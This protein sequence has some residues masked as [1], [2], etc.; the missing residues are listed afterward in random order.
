MEVLHEGKPRGDVEITPERRKLTQLSDP[1][2]QLQAFRWEV[3]RPGVML[4]LT[5]PNQVQLHELNDVTSSW[6]SKLKDQIRL[7]NDVTSSLESKLKDQQPKDPNAALSKRLDD[8]DAEIKK[9]RKALEELG[10]ASK[11]TAELNQAI[12]LLKKLSA[13]KK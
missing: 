6:E 9:L 4:N 1:T 8:L 2:Q 13:D 3:V 11:A 10:G 5:S 12:E 7:L